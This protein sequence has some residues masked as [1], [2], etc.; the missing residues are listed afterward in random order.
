[1]QMYRPAVD[2]KPAVRLTSRTITHVSDWLNRNS[3]EILRVSLGMIFLLFGALKFVPGA[4][5]AE[6]LVMRT[7]D[8]LSM[9]LVPGRAAVVITAMT[10]CFIG[11]TLMSGRLL[12]SGLCVLAI[13]LVGIMSPLVLFYSDLFP[14]APTI[15]GQY[16]L[17]DIVLAAAGL[18]IAARALGG[19]LVSDDHS[20]AER[21]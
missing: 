3:I 17:K 5:P 16:V 19:R 14:G 12:R 18:V 2:A 1:M 9:G 8:T 15:E 10:E 11:I 6:E 7:L 13:S 21:P 4:S 20:G